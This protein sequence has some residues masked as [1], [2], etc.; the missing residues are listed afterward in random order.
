ME[1]VSC[2]GSDM[3]ASPFER[4]E[5]MPQIGTV[6][7]IDDFVGK[8]AQVPNLSNRQ[9]VGNFL[10]GLREELQIR[11]Q[12]DA[13]DICRNMSIA[14]EIER[15]IILTGGYHPLQ[16]SID[17]CK[18]Q[19][20]GLKGKLKYLG[21]VSSYASTS[22]PISSKSEAVSS[23]TP[24][25]AIMMPSTMSSS[26]HNSTFPVKSKEPGF[27]LTKSIRNCVEDDLGVDTR[28]LAL[29]ECA[30][31]ASSNPGSLETHF[32]K[33]E[34]PL[35]S[36][37][38]STQSAFDNLKQIMVSTPVLSMPNF[39]LPFVIEC[40]ASS[41]GVG[42]Y[43][44]GRINGIADALSPCRTDKDFELTAIC[45]PQWLDLEDIKEAVQNDSYHR[46]IIY[47]PI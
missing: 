31:P 24:L 32:T 20:S 40:D 10:N 7:Y 3:M 37:G 15:K 2:Y 36:V 45:H 18:Q 17:H 35:F 12:N 9:Y 26:S 19:L 33:M 38:A 14:Q 22:R 16:S 6:D 41:K 43:K 30:D 39:D 8:A 21:P 5:A 27:I 11:L 13:T 25:K 44:P 47:K 23:P 42:A 1:L 29:V 34:L 46:A 28:D 4:L